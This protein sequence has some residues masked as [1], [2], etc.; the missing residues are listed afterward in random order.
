MPLKKKI[1]LAM[2]VPA[3]LICT[4]G[5]AGVVSLRYLKQAAGRIL[6]HNYH[7]IEEARSIEKSLRLLES[8]KES[9][10]QIP[11]EKV[12]HD[13]EQALLRCE[14]NIT[15]KGESEILTKIRGEWDRYKPLKANTNLVKSSNIIHQ[16]IDSLISINEQ[17]MFRYEEQTCK[18]A[19]ITL[20]G[21][22]TALTLA[23]GTL[24]S[25]SLIS[26][27]RISTPIVQV[28]S[29]LHQALNLSENHS[30]KDL[31]SVDEIA[32]LKE[33]L[34]KLLF[35]LAQYE[36][37]QRKRLQHM[38]SRLA[39]VIN[40]VLEGLVLIDD[41]KNIVAVNRIARQILGI[42]NCDGKR[43]DEIKPR[44]DV[45]A[46]LQP[47][48]QGTYQPERDLGE[49][50]FLIEGEQRVYRPRVLTV[51]SKIDHIDGFLL[52]FWDVT[53][54]RKFEDSR[55][56]FISM[57]SHQLKTPMTSLSMSVN[58]LKEK[59]KTI[60]PSQTELLSIASEDCN[61]LANLISDLIEAAKEPLPDLSL[62]FYKIDIVKL[63]RT[64]LRPLKTQA[65]D[66]G[67]TL[68]IPSE[69]PLRAW[70]D[71]VKFPWVIT[72]I[73]GN[74]LRYT[75]NGGKIEVIIEKQDSDFTVKIID[76]GSGISQDD[77]ASIF[78]PYISLDYEPE[79]GTHGLG[80]TIA[81]EIVEA[82]RGTITVESTIGK[83][84]CFQINV[85]FDA[86]EA[87]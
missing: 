60:D 20:W 44:E 51:A 13:I 74:A 32:L 47:I 5:I 11:S 70:V 43:L 59:I 19:D 2:V 56:K 63:L 49:I 16:N 22:L 46:M 54:Q 72:N 41:D 65:E 78:E 37:E 23:I 24:T 14:R 15:E 29:R 53:E 79:Q 57:L 7:T 84:T 80:L 12:I 67:I 30:D 4:V 1:L 66:K 50:K 82:H 64:G 21:L 36:D 73:A 62:R 52:L 77:I 68:T 69:K 38:Q 6:S 61:S 9:E 42:N 48:I 25:F 71:P 83:G 17:A 26:A 76:T 28:A 58:L 81:K 45:R 8:Q 86:R 10:F 75:P 39:F 31:K 87:I 18:T 85:P 35:R 55:R 40:E 27:R 33:E 3:L 34:D